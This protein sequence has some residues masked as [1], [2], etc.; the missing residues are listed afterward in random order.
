MAATTRLVSVAR[1]CGWHPDPE[2]NCNNP[3]WSDFYTGGF[4]RSAGD[5]LFAFLQPMRI[6]P[7]RVPPALRSLPTAA[8][9]R[10]PAR[11]VVPAY[12]GLALSPYATDPELATQVLLWL[13]EPRQQRLLAAHGWLPVVEAVAQQVWPTL[14][15]AMPPFWAKFDAPGYTDVQEQITAGRPTNPI[16]LSI[17]V[18][19]ACQ[20]LYGGA[21]RRG[22][23]PCRSDW[24]R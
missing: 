8:F 7:G 23:P 19:D 4:L 13:Y 17:A 11:D 18:E 10:M 15:G 22:W 20:A 12:S 2:S 5:A 24:R 3:H 14:R 21:S 1:G 9:P 16:A 6:Y